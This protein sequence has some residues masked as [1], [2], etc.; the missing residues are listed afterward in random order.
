MTIEDII[1]GT[2]KEIIKHLNKLYMFTPRTSSNLNTPN[3]NFDGYDELSINDQLDRISK[4]NS[5]VGLIV[6]LKN[7]DLD[8]KGILNIE[9]MKQWV[10]IRNN[11]PLLNKEYFKKEK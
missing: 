2:K 1:C 8:S 7:N 4:F 10:F 9:L 3:I 11:E 6:W 5:S